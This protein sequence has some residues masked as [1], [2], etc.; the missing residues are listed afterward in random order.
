[1]VGEH[2]VDLGAKVRGTRTAFRFFEAGRRH[3]Q[4]P[5]KGERLRPTMSPVPTFLYRIKTSHRASIAVWFH[6]LE[7][8]PRMIPCKVVHRRTAPLSSLSTKEKKKRERSAGDPLSTVDG[9]HRLSSLFLCPW[10]RFRVVH[11]DVSV[12][13]VLSFLASSV[14]YDP[15]VQGKKG[16]VPRPTNI[17]R[18]QDPIHRS[19]PF[20]HSKPVQPPR[21]NRSAHSPTKTSTSTGPTQRELH[22]TL[23]ISYSHHE[24]E[25]NNTHT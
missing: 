11:G 20:P 24:K 23:R 3:V 1:M 18:A 8:S 6:S 13:R 10:R 4:R 15:A 9:F 12:R 21:R 14:L 17:S 16:C 22:L 25:G 5:W 19:F 7:Q 2:P